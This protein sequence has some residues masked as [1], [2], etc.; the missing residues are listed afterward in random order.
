MNFMDL[1]SAFPKYFLI[2]NASEFSKL[3]DTSSR[4]LQ[5]RIYVGNSDCTAGPG[6]TV[7]TLTRL[8]CLAAQLGKELY[9]ASFLCWKFVD[10]NSKEHCQKYLSCS[11]ETFHY[12]YE[13]FHYTSWIVRIKCNSTS[14]TRYCLKQL[15]YQI[16]VAKS[17]RNSTVIS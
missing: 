5:C 9:C 3:A 15:Q 2:L 12:F 7:L 4:N 17:E 1:I 13:V 10:K 8:D 11:F 14:S 6:S 16:L